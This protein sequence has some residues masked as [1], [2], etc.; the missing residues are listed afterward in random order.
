MRLAVRR[1]G[2]VEY[3]VATALQERCVAQRTA[4]GDDVLLLLEHSPVYTL[5]RAADPRF[6]GGAAGGD[7]PI[8]QTSRGGQVT[9]HGP[10]Q[11]VGYPILDLRAHRCDVRWYVRQLEAVLIGALDR[12]GVVGERRLG[13]PGVWTRGRKVASIGI[14]IRRWI[15][16]HG[17]ALNVGADLTAFE[18]ITPC[19]LDGVCMTSLTGEGV[20]AGME[21][22][23]TVVRE[24]FVHRFGYTSWGDVDA[25]GAPPASEVRA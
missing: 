1:L 8:V 16:W 13:A 6:L 25:E 15:T 4:G 11:L 18:R 7:V 12:L 10:G 24:E 19:G 3:R 5:G 20:R 22:V 14:A 23:A 21:D 9:Y 17:F 2:V